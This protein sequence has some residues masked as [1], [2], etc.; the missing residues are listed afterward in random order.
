MPSKA[1]RGFTITQLT[2]VP[3]FQFYEWP[4]T[5]THTQTDRQAD[6]QTDRQT[7][8]QKYTARNNTC[9][10]SMMKAQVKYANCICIQHHFLFMFITD[11]F[12]K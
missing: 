1:R 5:K 6:R 10:V 11:V 3:V 7:D 12:K 9:F 8:K 4:E 2:S